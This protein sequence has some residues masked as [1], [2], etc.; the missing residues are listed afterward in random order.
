MFPWWNI[1]QIVLLVSYCQLNALSTQVNKR[2]KKKNPKPYDLQQY[3]EN[4]EEN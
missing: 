3:L 1:V 4:E 2:K